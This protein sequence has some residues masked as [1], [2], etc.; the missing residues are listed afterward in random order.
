MNRAPLLI[1]FL[2]LLMP[3]FLFQAEAPSV[4]ITSPIAGQAIQGAV[5]VRG[6]LSLEPFQRA[7]LQFAYADDP[8]GTWFLIAEF[9]QPVGEGVLA[10]WDTSAITDGVYHLRLVVQGGDGVVVEARVDNLRVRNYTPVETPTPLPSPVPTATLTPTRTPVPTPT[11][12][13]PNPVEVGRDVVYL[14]L[15]RGALFS[16][17]SLLLFGFLL[18]LRRRTIYYD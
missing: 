16:V 15:G 12:P 14:S 4:A 13:L 1:A 2:F 6:T 17:L 3:A 5:E 10:V 8:T 11:A 9:D 7:E 18:W